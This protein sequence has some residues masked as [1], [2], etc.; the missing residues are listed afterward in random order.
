MK[1]LFVTYKCCDEEIQTAMTEQELANLYDY[2]EECGCIEGEILA[3]EYNADTKQ[4]E[5]V[6]VYDIVKPI[7]EQKRWAE[8]EYR[9][10]CEMVNEYGYDYN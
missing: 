5:R 4:M 7:L 1:K 8:Q 10:Y 6:D 3:F 9:D 2:D